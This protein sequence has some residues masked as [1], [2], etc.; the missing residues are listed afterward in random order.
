MNFPVLFS[1]LAGVAIFTR[2]SLPLASF[3]IF[4]DH[5]YAKDVISINNRYVLFVGTQSL[6]LT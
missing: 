3:T 1:V 5:E 2:M 6:V 4:R